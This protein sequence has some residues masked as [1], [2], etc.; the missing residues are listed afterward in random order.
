MPN[1][2]QENTNKWVDDAKNKNLQDAAN[3]SNQVRK[4]SYSKSNVSGNSR[5]KDF[6]TVNGTA[7]SDEDAR[8]AE[9]QQQQANVTK[10]Q[11]DGANNYERT[12]SRMNPVA[13]KITAFSKAISSSPVYSTYIY[14][15]I[16]GLE[17]CSTI[18]DPTKNIIMSLDNKKSGCGKANTF[19]LN[20]AYAVDPID[21]DVNYIDRNIAVF[22]AEANKDSSQNNTDGT[23][24]ETK[25]DDS[26]SLVINR[27]CYLRYGYSS[28]GTGE[29]KSTD[30]KDSKIEASEKS[31]PS[32]VTSHSGSWLSPMYKG[33]L[34][35]YTCEFQDGILYY[36][37]TGYS[38]L[39][40][41][42]ESKDPLKINI[43]SEDG[44]IRPTRAVEQLVKSYLQGG[45]ESAEPLIDGDDTLAQ[46]TY[47][48][49]SDDIYYDIVFDDNCLG[50]DAPV[51]LSMQLDKNISQAIS[52]ILASA[53]KEDEYEKIEADSEDPGAT[54]S[55]KY[56][57]YIEDS[58]ENTDTAAS[59]EGKDEASKT[60]VEKSGTIHV[61]CEKS[62]ILTEKAGELAASVDLTFN[63]MSPG[64]TISNNQ[65][66]LNNYTSIIL[67]FQPEYKGSAL[68]A[69]AAKLGQ[70][71]IKANVITIFGREINNGDGDESANNSE[72]ST[73]KNDV[74][75]LSNQGT[76]GNPSTNSDN[77]TDGNEQPKEINYDGSFY[78]KDDGTIGKTLRSIAPPAGGS[79]SGITASVQQ[80]RSSW[81][82]LVQ[83]PYT[84][85]MTTLGIPEDIPITGLIQVNPIIYG[86]K[87]HSAGVYR[88]QTTSD[89]ISAGGQFT[90]TWNLLKVTESL[91]IQS[92]TF[93][94]KPSTDATQQQDQPTLDEM[95]Q[96]PGGGAAKK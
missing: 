91:Q 43:N 60:N 46:P 92:E 25:S 72:P 58:V 35:D 32:N 51:E 30:I 26:V 6:S 45:R 80:E 3:Q 40:A 56:N 19:T 78:M 52:D 73:T 12:N 55:A 62:E 70:G 61:F 50:S 68:V 48:P 23:A 94:D 71:K 74:E 54:N 8:K 15:K 96:Q 89:T 4:G 79:N 77:Q 83:Y 7:I 57:W 69:N 39:V 41:L 66:T 65:P 82:D 18:Q 10:A 21:P 11:P 88:I 28:V 85:T 24:T 81:A 86:Q 75:L 31:L 20:I 87:H 29:F 17:L 42:N 33:M 95:D 44:K 67:N 2:F 64:V 59:E 27:T 34:T 22:T 38:S 9:E 47:N 36:T 49:I 13:S 1:T 90:T 53:T 14:F 63:W 37:L 76:D 84:A 5:V 93:D 16:N